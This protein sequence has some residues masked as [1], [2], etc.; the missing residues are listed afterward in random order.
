[1]MPRPRGLT[2]GPSGA[3]AAAEVLALMARR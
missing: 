1:V 3:D 2:F